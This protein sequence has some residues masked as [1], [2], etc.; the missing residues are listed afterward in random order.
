ML[1]SLAYSVKSRPLDCA[2][3]GLPDVSRV[4]R[5]IS[6]VPR[7][8]IGCIGDIEGDPNCIRLESAPIRVSHT[9]RESVHLAFRK[10]NGVCTILSRARIVPSRRLMDD[11]IQRHKFL[12]YW[13][14]LHARIHTCPRAHAPRND[15]LGDRGGSASWIVDIEPIVVE[16]SV[17]AYVLTY[18]PMAHHGLRGRGSDLL[19][20]RFDGEQPREIPHSVFQDGLATAYQTLN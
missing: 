4:I 5:G 12:I 8:W 14:N 11:E 19:R 9:L 18:C 13:R 7:R 10:Q 15:A 17:P 3:G 2:E 20:R 6:L 16:C 1:H